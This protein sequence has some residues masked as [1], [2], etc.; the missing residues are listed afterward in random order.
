ME[1]NGYWACAENVTLPTKPNY[2]PFFWDDKGILHS[3]IDQ[4]GYALNENLKGQPMNPDEPLNF[5]LIMCKP[6]SEI[7]RTLRGEN[8]PAN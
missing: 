7:D 2:T 3:I 4:L 1:D 5:Y 8:V 6:N